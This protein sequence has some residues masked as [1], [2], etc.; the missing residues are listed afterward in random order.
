MARMIPTATPTPRIGK[1]ARSKAAPAWEPR[2]RVMESPAV[3]TKAS[4]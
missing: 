1:K 4:A 2:K 3:M